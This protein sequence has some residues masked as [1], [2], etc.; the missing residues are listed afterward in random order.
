MYITYLRTG[1]FIAL[2]MK[3]GVFKEISHLQTSEKLP[4]SS[5]CP[6]SAL[7]VYLPMMS[8][9]PTLKMGLLM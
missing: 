4:K 5:D 6:G 3:V 1:F 2:K 8:F 9:W 7:H